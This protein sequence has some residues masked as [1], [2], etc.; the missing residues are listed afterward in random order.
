VN[1]AQAV[2]IWPLPIHGSKITLKD[3]ARRA[4]SQTEECD[5]AVLG[6]SVGGKNIT[7][8]SPDDMLMWYASG[9][10]RHSKVWGL[11]EP[12]DTTRPHDLSGYTLEWRGESI[13][14]RNGKAI[15]GNLMISERDLQAFVDK[16]RK[17]PDASI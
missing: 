16:V 9:L 3:A 11:K 2:A 17:F 1:R 13:I 7:D 8:A 4:Y 14:G 12:S 5:W 10:V 6:A 15:I